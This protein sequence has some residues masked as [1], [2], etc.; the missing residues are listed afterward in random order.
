[1]CS[2]FSETDT[3]IIKQITDAVESVE[4]VRLLDVDRA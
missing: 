2:N 4:G 3:R 1:M